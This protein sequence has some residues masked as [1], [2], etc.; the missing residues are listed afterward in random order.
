[1]ATDV[2][3]YASLESETE[4]NYLS[5][6][7]DNMN[8][9]F[10]YLRED[11]LVIMRKNIEGSGELISITKRSKEPWVMLTVKSFIDQVSKREC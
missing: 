11:K 6:I 4:I 5:N 9:N 2:P 8:Q 3:S 7:R 10:H 1:M